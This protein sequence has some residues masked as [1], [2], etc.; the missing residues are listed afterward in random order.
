MADLAIGSAHMLSQFNLQVIID[1]EIEPKDLEEPTEKP[2]E[3]YLE[4]H[5]THR[6][7]GLVPDHIIDKLTPLERV[8]FAYKGNHFRWPSDKGGSAS[9]SLYKCRG[10]A[11]ELGAICGGIVASL[12]SANAP[13][14]GGSWP[15][16]DIAAKFQAGPGAFSCINN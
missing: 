5:P 4:V 8:A 11:A 6:G 16:V 14:N 7:L 12:Y 10:K 13:R 2:L 1:E 15:K 3:A 9:L